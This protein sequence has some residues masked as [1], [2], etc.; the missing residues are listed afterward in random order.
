[1]GQGDS[2]TVGQWDSGNSETET[3][4]QGDSETE[5]VRQGDSETGRQWDSGT[6][7]Q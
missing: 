7:G 4:G 1:M 5:T 2:G 6:G 3:V